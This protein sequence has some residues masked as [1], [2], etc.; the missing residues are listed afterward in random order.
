MSSKVTSKAGITLGPVTK[1]KG[2]S[3]VVKIA[4]VTSAGEATFAE[5]IRK[6][7]VRR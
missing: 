5:S 2:G 6:K 4:E 7:H 1:I 3:M